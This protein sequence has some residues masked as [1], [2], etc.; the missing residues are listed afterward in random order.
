MLCG[1]TILPPS[2]FTLH[3]TFFET[4]VLQSPRDSWELDSFVR[5][6]SSLE[7]RLAKNGDHRAGMVLRGLE[8]THR[9]T[10]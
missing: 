10:S 2:G 3:Y 1:S 7:T 9:E 8:Q 5:Y 4:P 6:S